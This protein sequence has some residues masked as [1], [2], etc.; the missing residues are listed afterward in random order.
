[1]HRPH[2]GQ[3]ASAAQPG[4]IWLISGT[5]EGPPLAEE[6]LRRGW[7]LR[8]SV[9]EASAARAYRPQPGL[10]LCPGAL[11]GP[12]A[13]TRILEDPPGFR[14]VV[15][16]THPFARLIS[17]QLRQ[18]CQ[19]WGQ[20]LL[21]LERPRLAPCPP[22]PAGSPVLLDGLEPLAELDLRAERLLLAIGSRHLAGAIA[23]SN[24]AAHFARI[25]DNPTSLQ[26][27][28]ASGLPDGHLACLRPGDG[29][30][31]Q[32]LCRHWRITAV[33]CRESGGRTEQ[34]W[35]QV[36]QEL[37]LQLL[38]LR[39]PEPETPGL[40]MAKLLQQLGHPW[41]GIQPR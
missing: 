1:M 39:R 31:E 12:E 35:R 38:L 28:L 5:G 37:G 3:G 16:A 30:L 8:V 41:E 33:L 11:A 20:S 14:W 27:A 17:V 25:L 2:L 36:S 24:A 22:S 9:V 10:E 40:P 21:R 15:D 18:A 34:I 19:A 13:I 26:L 23:R 6:L 32:A 4:R 7:Q 29:R